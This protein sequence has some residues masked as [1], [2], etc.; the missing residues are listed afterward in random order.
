MSIFYYLS[1][2]CE[3]FFKNLLLNLPFFIFC[4]IKFF[5]SLVFLNDTVADLAVRYALCGR[6][7]LCAHCRHTVLQRLSPAKQMCCTSAHLHFFSLS[8]PLLSS[9][10]NSGD[11]LG[12]AVPPLP[13]C[14]RL[15]SLTSPY[16][17]FNELKAP[18]EKE[19]S[20]FSQFFPNLSCISKPF[21]Q[22]TPSI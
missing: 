7:T 16:P 4:K 1:K 14:G 11:V 15:T 9:A 2:K 10:L 17:T 12:I 6:Y 19:F 3:I 8:N 20:N 21:N 13:A 5:E 18:C 22:S